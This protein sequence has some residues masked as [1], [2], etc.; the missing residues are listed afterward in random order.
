MDRH[1]SL[2]DAARRD[3]EPEARADDD[4]PGRPPTQRFIPGLPATPPAPP[5][6]ASRDL[7]PGCGVAL[8][9]AAVLAVLALGGAYAVSLA[10]RSVRDSFSGLSSEFDMADLMDPVADLAI[11]RVSAAGLTC[12]WTKRSD[13]EW[14]CSLS[15]AARDTLRLE[16]WT[17]WSGSCWLA[18]IDPD[19][20][21]ESPGASASASR[22]RWVM[23]FHPASPR[24]A[25]DRMALLQRIGRADPTLHVD[26]DCA[27]S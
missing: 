17:S 26:L 25:A 1:E 22:D 11:R 12:E 24:T 2:A 9:I 21:A 15:P 8:A 16:L 6:G 14:E 13:T 3:D 27:R 4:E 20:G 18:G 23:R 19:A 7:P 10:D 5:I